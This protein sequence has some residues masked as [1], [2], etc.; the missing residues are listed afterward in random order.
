MVEPRRGAPCD[1][2]RPNRE[3][4]RIDEHTQE[5]REYRDD[6]DAATDAGDSFTGPE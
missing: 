5:R 3:N 1:E 6:A 4:Y 2:R